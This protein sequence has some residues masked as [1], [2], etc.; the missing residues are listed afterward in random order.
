MKKD[1]SF[2]SVRMDASLLKKL[3]YIAA[4]N[5]RSMNTTLVRLVCSYIVRF[6]KE[7]GVISETE[8]II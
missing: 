4:Y 6:E 8:E 2:L 1:C 7:H 5:G 3:K